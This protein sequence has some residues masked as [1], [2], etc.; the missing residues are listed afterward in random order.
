MLINHGLPM[1][2]SGASLVL[3]A[4]VDLATVPRQKDPRNEMI[5]WRISANRILDVS[6]KNC[7]HRQSTGRERAP[8]LQSNYGEKF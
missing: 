2:S 3:F 5:W 6:T 8:V 1:K 7:S 4:P